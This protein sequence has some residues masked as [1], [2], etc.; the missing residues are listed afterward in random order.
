MLHAAVLTCYPMADKTRS[1]VED[2]RGTSQL[3]VEATKGV[4]SLVEAMHRTIGGGPAI[5]GKP[6]EAPTRLATGIVY[7][8][9]RAATSLVGAGI[10]GALEQLAPLLGDTAPGPERAAVL[11]AL[12]GV[13]GDYL[14]E[15][16][17][18]LAIECV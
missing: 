5:L 17:N 6:L 1:H 8:G 9:I 14:D 18:P 16:N 12:N 11:A 2:R 4:T 10:D 3:A 15:T 13:L 7:G